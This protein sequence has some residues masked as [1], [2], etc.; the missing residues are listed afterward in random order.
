MSRRPALDEI[1][2][3]ICWPVTVGAGHRLRLPKGV[4]STTDWLCKQEG[5]TNVLAGRGDRGGLRLY[6]PTQREQIEGVIKDLAESATTADTSARDLARWLG[7][8]WE[9]SVEADGRLI[10][11]EAPRKLGL[12]PNTGEVG[13]VF[14]YGGTIEIWRLQAWDRYFAERGT[15]LGQVVEES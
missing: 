5:P 8:T 12:A 4:A 2:P 11:P 14:A 1:R 15:E 13:V 9:V 10:L 3:W 6:S 7:M